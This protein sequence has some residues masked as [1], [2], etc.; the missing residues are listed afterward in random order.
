M[1]AS[2]RSQK[3]N[4]ADQLLPVTLLSGFL[5][6]GKTTLLERILTDPNHGLRIGVIVNDVGALN[7]DAAL[8][9]N[10]DVTRKE[11]QV[12]AMQNGCICCTLVSSFTSHENLRGDLL[13][14]VARLADDRKVDY[15]VI[16]SSGVSEPQQVAETFS[17]E[18][19]EQHV[20]AGFDLETDEGHEMEKDQRMRLASILKAGGLPQVARLD[21]CVTVVDAVNFMQDFATVDMIKDRQADVPEEDERN[22][23]DLQVDQIEFADVILINKCDLVSNND[24]GR[25]RDIIKHLNSNA[26]TY[27]TTKSQ[28]DLPNILNTRLFSYEK[29]RLSAGWLKSLLEKHTPETEEYGIGTFV[30]SA[31]RP[32]HPERLW[33]MIKNVFVVNQ[34]S[35]QGVEDDEDMDEDENEISSES[36]S[37]GSNDEDMDDDNSD[38]DDSEMSQEEENAQPQLDLK[39]RLA[40]KIQDS[41]FGPLLRSKGWLWLA[42]RPSMYGE[43]SQAGVMLT[44]SGGDKWFCEIPKSEWPGDPQAREMINRDFDNSKWGDRRQEIVFIGQKMR[45]GGEA[46]LRSALDACLLDDGEFGAW[47]RAMGSVKPQRALDRLFEDG[48]EDWYVME[49]DHDHDHSHEDDHDHVHF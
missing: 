14:E 41:T 7:I 40:S 23:S 39:A 32:F 45:D 16:E 31:R 49:H 35:Y 47:E 3:S 13:E 12:V 5:G 46:R 15:L 26:K 8:L 22:V 18:F 37:Q 21:T 10:H 33:S 28:V 30:Y 1:A 24:I 4:E 38:D 6:A 48:F 2:T 43:W 17:Q 44:I 34:M 9:S 29:A 11:E 19:S 20:A 42:T 25:I 27:T 36:E